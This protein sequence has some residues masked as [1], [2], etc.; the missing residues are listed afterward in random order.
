M[1]GLSRALF[2]SS[3]LIAACTGGT[4]DLRG[5]GLA[6]AGRDPGSP[7]TDAGFVDAGG[8]PE[9]IGCE[10]GWVELVR[11][12]EDDRLEGF[13]F[14]ARPQG[15]AI[16]SHEHGSFFLRFFD[17]QGLNG[18]SPI[19]VQSPEANSPPP[20]ILAYQAGWLT[21]EQSRF[22]TF[23]SS[24][25]LAGE[26]RL[27]GPF[28][29]MFVVSE[30]VLGIH[31][32]T[33]FD[34]DLGSFVPSAPPQ[35]ADFGIRADTGDV[36]AFGP[37]RAMVAKNG[38]FGEPATIEYYD[39]D[40]PRPL[41]THRLPVKTVDGE[42]ILYQQVTTAR[43][44][45]RSTRFLILAA[46]RL[47]STRQ[48]GPRLMELD[49]RGL[50]EGPALYEDEFFVGGYEGL[51]GDLFIGDNAIAVAYGSPY[52]ASE[53]R[54]DK[55]YSDRVEHVPMDGAAY[56]TSPM[57]RKIDDRFAIFYADGATSTA[58]WENVLRMRCDIQD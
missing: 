16:T 26:G 38:G 55:V 4:E 9:P 58:E 43:W 10:R 42:E 45:A 49:D 2:L 11:A 14:A 21:F 50:S 23:N 20:V 8:A 28:E 48:F 18:T 7:I 32:P 47:G 12:R 24:G 39:L 35:T 25:Q 5:N 31:R 27:S 34:R 54:F 57:I 53:I 44:N 56:R 40:D 15:F 41:A 30:T 36:V 17:R 19:Y 1:N 46:A 37:N 52:T 33:L 3:S 22:E 29:P 51:K 6:D 13:S